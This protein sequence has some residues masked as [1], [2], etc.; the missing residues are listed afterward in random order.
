MC[1]FWLY[2]D[3]QQLWQEMHGESEWDTSPYDEDE[4]TQVMC[5]HEPSQTLIWGKKVCK[6]CGEHME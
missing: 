2:W 1:T 4:V 5:L 6:H 3:E